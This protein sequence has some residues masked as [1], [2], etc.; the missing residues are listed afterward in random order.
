M[1][2]M[3][4]FLCTFALIC[5]GLFAQNLPADGPPPNIVLILADDVGR[6]VIGCYGGTSYQ[7]PNIDRLAA[8]GMRCRHA[9]AMPV[10]HPTRT[11]LLTGQYPFRLGHPEWGTFPRSAENRTLAAVLKR[12]GYA[13]AIAGKWQLALLKND[14]QQPH[15]MGFDEYCLYGWHEGPWYYQPH[16]WQNGKFR[17]D[18][19]ERY[20]PDVICDYTI[21]FIARNKHRPFFVFYSMELC[22]A[23]TNDLKKPA[24]VGPNGRYDSYAAMVDKMD[25]RVGRVVAALDR[26]GLRE[27]TLVIFTSDNGT[28]SR[29]LV[30]AVGDELVYEPV[31]SKMG[32]REIPGGKATLSDWGARV[33]MIMNWPGTIAAGQISDALFDMSDILPSLADVAEANVPSDVTLDG[34]SLTANLRHSVPPRDWVFAE[35][36]GMCFIRSQRWKLYNDGRFYDMD[37]DPDEKHSIAANAQTTDAAIAHHDLKHALD[38]LNYVKP[39]AKSDP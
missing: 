28:A 19:R 3:S 29:T 15:R 27:R 11:T 33:P 23:E 35:H 32:D 24:P 5:V 39:P 1:I 2:A 26:L 20:G 14:S 25:E 16:I 10:C 12:A 22:H 6:E 13:T 21:E 31:V 18:V 34:H 36:E 4:R 8:N 30:D 37:N 7:T 38:D 17:N 9:Y